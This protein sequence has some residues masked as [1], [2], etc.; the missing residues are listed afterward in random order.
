MADNMQIVKLENEIINL[1]A[2]FYTLLNDLGGQVSFSKSDYLEALGQ[3][4][5]ITIL[6]S[7]DE[8]G[9]ICEG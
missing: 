4:R 6:E 7:N 1:H 3:E 8:V 2:L 5:R 9:V